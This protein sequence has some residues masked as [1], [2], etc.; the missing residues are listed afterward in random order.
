MKINSWKIVFYLLFFAQVLVANGQRIRYSINENWHFIRADVPYPTQSLF[1]NSGRL[2]SFPHTWN[3]EDVMDDTPG[4]Y[5]N[6]AW[7][8]RNI[9]IPS[10]Y[11]EKQL[12]LFFEG[13][14]Q[15][16]ELF[17]NGKSVGV[18]VGG[19]TRFSF[20]ITDYVHVGS[21]NQLVIKVNN[22][23][24]EDIPPLSADFT[25]FGGIY[26]DV[27]MIVTSGQH[28]STTHYA[29]SGVY[30]RTPE[31]SQE[32]ARL[33]IKTMLTNAAS[34][35]KNIRIE[36]TVIGPDKNV[37][38]T[39]S[40][41]IKL[42]KNSENIP[43]EQTLK[44]LNPGL[45]SPEY[46]VLYGVYTRVYDVGNKVLLDEVYQPLGFRWFEFTTEKGFVLNGKPY[47][48]IGTNR[49]QCFDKMGNALPD[50]IHIRDVKLLKDMGAN[51]LRV[52]HYPQDP[53]VMEL[54]DKLGIITSVEIPIVNAITE[55][56]EFTRNS[57]EMARE[58]V[59][60]DYNRPSVLVW[61][62]MNEVLLKLPFKNDTVL[63]ERYLKSVEVLAKKIEN[64]IRLDDP[65][66][67]TMIPFHGSIDLYYNSGLSQIP[68][69]V[70]WNL[71]QGWYG[72]TFDK[73]DVFLDVAHEKMKGKP[74]I[75]T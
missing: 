30:L 16:V 48:L 62:Y 24:N 18:H 58:M 40:K 50:E 54:C 70:G 29:S 17:V 12:T 1:E 14:N 13:A 9:N 69:I 36:H 59:F 4:Y 37:V 45:W 39:T 31:V 49:H 15:E 46:P 6:I 56:Q 19:Y 41:N 43:S 25:F 57:I 27:Y 26:R 61:A 11:K 5:R 20:N 42:A 67:Y 72:G 2:V 51:F 38:I 7:Y 63:H 34:V 47:K 65:D 53:T 66:R 22:R 74:F 73:L 33:E 75:I 10:E 21:Q 32:K 71:Y 64:Q 68:M 52:S 55:S 60:Q 44:I 8:S 28:I 3:V 35:T 23:F